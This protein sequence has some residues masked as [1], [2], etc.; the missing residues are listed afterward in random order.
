MLTTRLA[1][2]VGIVA[3]ASGVA[4]AGDCR[5]K[6]ID[7]NEKMKTLEHVCHPTD[8]AQM[9]K[10]GWRAFYVVE[11]DAGTRLRRRIDGSDQ[12]PER[13]LSKPC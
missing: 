2:A 4:I 10:R 3:M 12:L 6:V 7:E 5:T 11:G 8:G 13:G 9:A 1:L